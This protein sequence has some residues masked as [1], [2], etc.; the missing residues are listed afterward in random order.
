MIS[1]E[2][3]INDGNPN[4]YTVPIT[5]VNTRQSILK[6]NTFMSVGHEMT[7][8]Q[9]KQNFVKAYLSATGLCYSS[10]KIEITIEGKKTSDEKKCKDYNIDSSTCLVINIL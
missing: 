5:V 3:M 7:M 8:K 10:R 2:K 9:V 6:H 1:W 4:T